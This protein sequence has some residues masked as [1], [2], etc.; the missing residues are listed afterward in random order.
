[1]SDDFLRDLENQLR[2]AAERRER[3]PW[4]RRGAAGG[5]APWAPRI[6][7]LA[8]AATLVAIV[9]AIALRVGPDSERDAAPA[10]RSGPVERDGWTAY[11]PLDDDCGSTALR[12]VAPALDLP[13]T[14]SAPGAVRHTEDDRGIA[15]D[16]A[17]RIVHEDG[18]Q[19]WV[20]PRLRCEDAA[21]EQDEV[22]I[23]PVLDVWE[24][25]EIAPR[26]CATPNE[27]RRDGVT[28]TFPVGGDGVAVAGLTPPLTQDVAVRRDGRL[29]A[30]LPA[31]EGAF[32]GMVGESGGE[33][34]GLEFE[35]ERIPLETR[36]V[37]VFGE[38]REAAEELMLTLQ[39]RGFANTSYAGRPPEPDETRMFFRGDA[40]AE[41]AR[42]V[43]EALRRPAGAIPVPD[44]WRRRAPEALV[45]VVAD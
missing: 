16:M 27:L 3:A 14:G 12:E 15:Q 26:V 24:R 31:V 38:R 6:A 18:V 19:Y 32:G 28:M 45:F 17:R 7:G 35:Y 10:D 9:A 29:I 11:T 23:V 2:A 30:R 1:M 13:R 21:V 4:W 42:G 20:V 8:L 5:G 39:R 22:C 44:R 37:A 34:S 33:V 41:M 25:D 36:P 43:E 40:G